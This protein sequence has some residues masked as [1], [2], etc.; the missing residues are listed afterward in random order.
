[1]YFS[2]NRLSTFSY[3][4]LLVLGEIGHCI[5]T[6]FKCGDPPRL[7]FIPMFVLGSASVFIWY[8]V[9]L[10]VAAIT[11]E[12]GPGSGIIL[13]LFNDLFSLGWIGT[14]LLLVPVPATV[15]LIESAAFLAIS[16][17]DRSIFRPHVLSGILIWTVIAAVCTVFL[18]WFGLRPIDAVA[19]IAW[20]FLSRRLTIFHGHLLMLAIYPFSSSSSTTTTP[21][22]H[23]STHHALDSSLSL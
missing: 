17:A 8:L 22:L 15:L 9:A 20:A 2:C 4:H 16:Q 18:L 12:Y 21:L 19:A 10:G 6:Q 23:T 11:D 5:S 3:K 1:M 7:S 14:L 13:Q